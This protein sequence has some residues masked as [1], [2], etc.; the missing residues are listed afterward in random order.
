MARIDMANRIATLRRAKG[1]TQKQLADQL[2]IADNAVSEWERGVSSPDIAMLHPLSEILEVTVDE[3]LV[4]M[5]E[6]E[7]QAPQDDEGIARRTA[8]MP[9]PR[10]IHFVRISFGAIWALAV[11]SCG[12][13]DLAV[14]GGFSW[15]FYVVLSSL[16]FVAAVFT[17]LLY[18]TRRSLS[19]FLATASVAVFPY[20]YVI[21]R[22]IPGGGWFWPIG[23]PCALIGV[24]SC[25]I[26]YALFFKTKLNRR[27]VVAILLLLSAVIS[28]AVDCIVARAVGGQVSLAETLLTVVGC[29]AG[30]FFVAI[31]GRHST[32]VGKH[33][34]PL[35]KR[36]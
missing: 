33:A 17:P 16:V 12:I 13:V 30:A 25:W 15:W 9:S 8:W 23:A 10:M 3:L 19:R 31:S 28:V 22:I 21:E 27:Y 7:P 24:V 36:T 4:E 18:G 1:L 5:A 34:V 26:A 32:Q 29:G 14:N 35:F 2:N 20:L 6:K 11:L